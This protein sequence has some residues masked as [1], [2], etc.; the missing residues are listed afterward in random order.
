MKR[1]MFLLLGVTILSSVM[2]SK[3]DEEKTTSPAIQILL[4][5]TGPRYQGTSYAS[6]VQVTNDYAFW[7]EDANGN[8]VKTLEI[9]PVV[10]TVDTTSAHGSHVEHLPNWMAASGITYED[11]VNQTGSGVPAMFDGI[12]GASPYFASETDEQTLTVEWDL[13]DADGKKIDSGVYY[14]CAESSNFTKDPD[15]FAINAEMMTLQINVGE[16]TFSAGPTTTN[17]KEMTGE[18]V[19]VPAKN[20]LGP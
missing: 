16:K 17:L 20:I 8:Y 19:S 1:M 13:A 9:T 2:C 6:T 11:L 15:S 4:K 12:T 7:I 3:D 14:C 18:F 5:L 10:V